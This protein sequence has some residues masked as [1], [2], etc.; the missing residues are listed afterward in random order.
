MNVIAGIT[1]FFSFIM[2]TSSLTVA[3]VNDMKAKEMQTARTASK[4]RIHQETIKACSEGKTH[5]IRY[6]GVNCKSV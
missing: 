2:A 6:N 4:E 3:I 1:L 5:Y